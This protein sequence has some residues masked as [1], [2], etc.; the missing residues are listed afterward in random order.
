MAQPAATI[1]SAQNSGSSGVKVLG[2]QDKKTFLELFQELFLGFFDKAALFSLPEVAHLAPLIFTFATAFWALL[3]FNK[4]LGIFAASSAE[5]WGVANI[6]KV[7]FDYTIT[8]YFGEEGA[9]D[10]RCKSQLS[11]ITPSRFASLMSDGLKKQIPNTNLYMLSFAS[12]YIMQSMQHFTKEMATF[13]DKFSNRPYLA[14]ATTAVVLLLYSIYLYMYSCSSLPILI[15]S[16]LCGIAAGI[17]ISYQNVTL[18][19][20]DAVNV[21]FIPYFVRKSGMDYV[22]VTPNA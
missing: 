17:L 9:P 18:F 11:S 13:G 6:L 16:I 8:P 22:C 10:D 1:S 15:I 19:G 20:K 3:T 14:L 2:S 7:M 12:S 4:S 5:A 21:M